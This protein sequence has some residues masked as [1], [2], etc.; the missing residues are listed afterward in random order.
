GNLEMRYRY[1]PRRRFGGDAVFFDAARTPA[2]AG[3]AEAWAPHVTGR[4]EEHEIDCEHWDMTTAEPLREIGKVL[5][6]EL[7]GVRH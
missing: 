5:A 4:V 6:E 7:R 2:A 3:G 1:V